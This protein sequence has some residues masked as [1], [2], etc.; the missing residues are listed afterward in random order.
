MMFWNDFL[1]GKKNQGEHLRDLTN[2]T[3][4]ILRNVS[5]YSCYTP[6]NPDQSKSNA[7]QVRMWRNISGIDKRLWRVLW[8]LR[9][10]LVDQMLYK[11]VLPLSSK[12]QHQRFMNIIFPRI[13][14]MLDFKSH[15]WKNRQ[16]IS[17]FVPRALWFVQQSFSIW[18]AVLLFIQSYLVSKWNYKNSVFN[19]ASAF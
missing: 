19:H 3:N 6:S 18:N 9:Y 15:Y 10:C 12:C 5:Q 17:V 14:I 2:P 16:G 13:S 7:R 4:W 8:E 11:L 1:V